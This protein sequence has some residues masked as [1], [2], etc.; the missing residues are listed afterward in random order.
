MNNRNY[1]LILLG[2]VVLS[3]LLKPLLSL[4]E[5]F[6]C[7]C[8]VAVGGAD[9][10]ADSNQ[11][12]GSLYSTYFSPWWRSY[13]N[14]PYAGTSSTTYDTLV[15]WPYKSYWRTPLNYYNY[16][17]YWRR[18]QYHNYWKRP[19]YYRRPVQRPFVRDSV[20][21]RRSRKRVFNF[22]PIRN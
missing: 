4:F 18:P 14:G 6:G 11:E 8:A 13:F 15:N 1:I 2:I 10:D 21:G 22:N 3:F 17:S 16:W 7:G 9:V 19:Y 12:G 5:G 20:L